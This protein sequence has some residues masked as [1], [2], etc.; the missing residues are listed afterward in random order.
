MTKDVPPY[1]IVVGV[2]AKVIK[3]RFSDSIIRE[4]EEIKWWDWPIGK[5]RDN[6]GLLLDKRLDERVIERMRKL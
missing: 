1:A 5:I 4:L 6:L 2:P 3:F